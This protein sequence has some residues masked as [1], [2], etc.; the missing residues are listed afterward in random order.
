MTLKLYFVILLMSFSAIAVAQDLPFDPKDYP[1][2]N[3]SG[4]RRLITRDISMNDN[5]NFLLQSPPLKTTLLSSICSAIKA[6][7][8]NAYRSD[9]TGSETLTS[10]EISMLNDTSAFDMLQLTEEWKI[11][12]DRTKIVV[13]IIGIAPMVKI[14]SIDGATQR[15]PLFWLHYQEIRDYLASL[16]VTAPS[17][18]DKIE[19]LRD[20]FDARYFVSSIHK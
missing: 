17:K 14:Y 9:S 8:I 16:K 13:R 18:K 7:T 19:N 1:T 15:V 20:V 5:G 4:N 6:G 11:S 2:L 10:G 3:W 12:Q